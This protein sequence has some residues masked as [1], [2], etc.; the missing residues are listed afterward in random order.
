[1]GGLE[2]D[3]G[4]ESKA[5]ARGN[6]VGNAKHLERKNGEERELKRGIHKGNSVWMW[7]H[8]RRSEAGA[9]RRAG[10]GKGRRDRQF[11]DFPIVVGINSGDAYVGQD[12]GGGVEV[13]GC[14]A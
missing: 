11:V 13:S 14:E 5:C 8:V 7:H 10:Q 4:F 3:G 2:S 9:R 1:M 6:G 12:G